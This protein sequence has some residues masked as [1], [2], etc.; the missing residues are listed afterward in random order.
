MSHATRRTDTGLKHFDQN[1]RFYLES[2]LW[3]FRTREDQCIG[4]FRYRSE[5]E[6][7][8]AHF[9]S[10]V[11][12]SEQRRQMASGG[13]KLHFRVPAGIRASGQMS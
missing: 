5:A 2:G 12:E 9:K 3:Y 6:T 11:R 4:P 10:R 1:D 13:G 7:M 8:L